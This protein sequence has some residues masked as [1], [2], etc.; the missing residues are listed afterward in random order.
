MSY[1]ISIQVKDGKPEITTHSGAVPDGAIV[2][3]GHE[4]TDNEG[5]HTQLGVYLSKV[6]AKP[7]T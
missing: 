2:I 5:T 1:N 6:P 3:N 7:A 4:H